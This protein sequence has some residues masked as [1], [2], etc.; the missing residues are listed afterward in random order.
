MLVGGLVALSAPAFALTINPTFV[1]NEVR[2]WSDVEKNVVWQAIN[3]WTSKI[4]DDVTINVNISFTTG[5]MYGGRW[6][7]SGYLGVDTL[8]WLNT[9]HSLFFNADLLTPDSNGSYLW[10]DPTPL[11]SNDVPIM[12]WDALSIAR[13]EIGHML[14]FTAGFYYSDGG[15]VD[16]WGS[17]MGNVGGNPV[18]DP[19]GLGVRMYSWTNLGHIYYDYGSVETLE[20]LWENPP[21]LMA[22]TLINSIRADISDTDL[23]MLSKAYGYTIVPEP[24]LAGLLATTVV[25]GLAR[26]RRRVA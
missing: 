17:Q 24:G 11:T 2:T 9:S 25:A 22:P 6:Q 19:D 15:T 4:A 13:H 5:E 8:P 1:D 7:G 16:R 18:F 12:A 20:D 10:F 26:R 14:G 21:D 23:Q 3:D